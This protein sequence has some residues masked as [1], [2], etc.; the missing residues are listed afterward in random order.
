MH[1]VEHIRFLN[2]TAELEKMQK[3]ALQETKDLEQLST[4]NALEKNVFKLL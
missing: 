1:S 4:T 2:K 3:R